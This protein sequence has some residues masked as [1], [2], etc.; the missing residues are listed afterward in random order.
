MD[1]KRA[2]IELWKAQMPPSKIRAQ[3]K[4]SEST[5]R[6]ILVFAFNPINPITSMPN[7]MPEVT[8]RDG[9]MA[10]YKY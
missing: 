4:M 10:K 6:R 7:R 8:S 1:D 3:L 5:L 9:G 2:A